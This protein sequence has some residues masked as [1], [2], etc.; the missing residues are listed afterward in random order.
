MAQDSQKTYPRSEWEPGVIHTLED[1]GLTTTFIQDLVLKVMYLRGQ[2]TGRV[3]AETIHLPFQ[4]VVSPALDFLKREQMC[5]VKGA[6]SL[7]PA[8]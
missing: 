1:T 6:G 3:I 2:L 8:S 5:E 7:G 4:G